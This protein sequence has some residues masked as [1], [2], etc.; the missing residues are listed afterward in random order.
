MAGTRYEQARP[1]DPAT[2]PPRTDALTLVV[3]IYNESKRFAAVAGQLGDFVAERGGRLVFVDDGSTDNTAE[4]VEQFI[5]GRPGENI[6]LIR[7]AHRGK[8]AA[9]QAGLATARVGIAAFC[10]VDL[11][12]P[13]SELALIIDAAAKAPVLAIGSRGTAASRLTR[14]Q[15]RA[16]EYLGRA[17]N[18]V[19]QLAVVPGI[20]DTQCG[21]KASRAETWLSIIGCCRQTGFAWDVE[22]IAVAR[23]LGVP[24][25]EIGIEWRHQDGSRVRPLTD[26]ARMLRAIPAIRFNVTALRNRMRA[27]EG[28][29]FDDANAARLAAADAE[30]WWFRN[31]ATFVSLLIRRFS[32]GAGWLVDV[33]AGSDGVTA[34]LGWPPDRTLAL[35]GDMQRMKTSSRR[36]AMMKVVCDAAA[37]PVCNGAA[38][39][40]CA[41]D[42]VQH[43]A[44]PGPLLREVARL[45][46][47]DGYVI[48]Q[49]PAHPWLWSDA[50]EL[51]GHDRRYTRRALRR[52][53][54]RSGLEVVWISHVFS[55]LTLPV[56][57]RRKRGGTAEHTLGLDVSSRLVEWASMLLTRAE[58]LLV[59][60][61]SLPIGTSV[62][63][64][65]RRAEGGPA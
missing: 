26:G 55:W 15:N 1:I 35:D 7:C 39:V 62:L 61:V 41:L 12:T 9:I 16:R 65:A 38:N 10:D 18:R 32:P 44:D 49:V 54:E 2:N 40:V 50:D 33:G 56:L 30:Y 48:V 28:G 42:V 3:P 4:M 31:E 27:N 36:H 47:P 6:E 25:Q 51:L 11:A 57:L 53:L 45:V 23:A 14:R 22:I 37:V 63:C 58:A 5:A 19:V 59:R 13:L 34:M 21:A 8:G 60:W 52:E 20:V 29:A 43:V 46:A 17:Y 24:V 64:V